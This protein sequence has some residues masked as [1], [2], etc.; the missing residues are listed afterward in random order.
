MSENTKV[1]IGVVV[2]VML[3]GI[4]GR[5]DYADALESENAALKIRAAQCQGSKIVWAGRE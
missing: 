1:W 4:V 5:M 3:L 2:L